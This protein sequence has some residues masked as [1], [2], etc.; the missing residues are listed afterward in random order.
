MFG[1]VRADFP[2]LFIKDDVLYKAMYCGVCKGIGETCGHCARM[3]LS[4]DVTFLSVLLHNILGIDVKIE[5]GHC[6]THRIRKKPMA[7]VDEL[8]RKLGAVNTELVY[9]KYTDDIQDGDRGRGKRLWFV[10]GHKKVLKKYPEINQ[11][12][13][14]NLAE[15]EKTEK[16]GTESV[17]RAADATATMLA[18]LSDYLLEDKKTEHTRALFYALGKWIYLIDALDDYDKD[19][20]KGAYNPFLLSYH[21]AN[22]KELIKEHGQDVEFIFH[23]LFYSIRENASKIKFHFNRDLTDNVLLRGLPAMTKRIASGLSCKGYGK[24]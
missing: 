23:T 24:M 22:K 6:L 13:A 21:S 1:Y 12:I 2:Y 17:D 3:G 19:K 15:Q 14:K 5:K 10:S 16:S 20:K 4:Y 7:E 18:E 8:T 11:I 9:Y